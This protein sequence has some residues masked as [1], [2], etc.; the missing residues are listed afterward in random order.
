MLAD[1]QR[2]VLKKVTELLGSDLDIVAAVANG[3]QLIEAAL[4][5]DPDLIV[6]DISLPIVNGITAAC[7]IACEHAVKHSFLLGHWS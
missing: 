3:E 5:L 2:E 1:D 6:L 4:Y 7:V